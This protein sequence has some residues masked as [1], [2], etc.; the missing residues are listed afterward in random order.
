[1]K[2]GPPKFVAVC[3]DCGAGNP[4]PAT[5]C[6]LC[7]GPL[8]P[9]VVKPQPRQGLG[10]PPPSS[11]ALRL[12]SLMVTIALIAVFLGV[13]REAPGLAI[14]LA[15]VAT[16]ALLVTFSTAWRRRAAGFPMS[17]TEKTG[18]FLLTAVITVAV[19]LGVLAI[20]AVAIV[21]AVL[22]ICSGSCN[23]H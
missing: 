3:P 14:L 22:V 16:P 13:A 18:T 2:P 9:G 21:A 20:A 1:M 4:E 12:S 11:S 10:P 7:D 6:W 8:S 23:L 17:T 5:A 15:I 19:I